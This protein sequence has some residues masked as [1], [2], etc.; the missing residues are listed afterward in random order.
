V[1]P[2]YRVIPIRPRQEVR[3]PPGIRDADLIA[4][5]AVLWVASVVRILGS[6]FCH[7]TFGAEPTIAL[8]ACVLLP[9]LLFARRV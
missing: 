6:I 4:P 7:E 5:F 1:N 8:L 9:Y 3:E 2:S